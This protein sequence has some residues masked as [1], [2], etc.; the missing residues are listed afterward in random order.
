MEDCDSRRNRRVTEGRE[1]REEVRQ[2]SALTEKVLRVEVKRV[3][4]GPE[5]YTWLSEGTREALAKAIIGENRDRCRYC[6]YTGTTKRVAVHVRQHFAR[7]YC[8]CGENR[9]SRDTLSEH[10]KKLRNVAGHS[11]VHE[12]DRP[13]YSTFT[14][15][16]GWI[17]PPMFPECRPTLGR[18]LPDAR[19]TIRERLEVRGLRFDP[20][21]KRR[22]QVKESRVEVQKR[23]RPEEDGEE[24]EVPYASQSKRCDTGHQLKSKSRE[25]SQYK[26]RSDE[27]KRHKSKSKSKEEEPRSKTK[28]GTK[29]ER[30][31]DGEDRQKYKKSKKNKSSKEGAKTSKGKEP[32]ERTE[33]EKGSPIIDLVDGSPPP[34]A[35]LPI[36]DEEVELVEAH[37]EVN[38]GASTSNPVVARQRTT[39]TRQLQLLAGAALLRQQ[40]ALFQLQAQLAISRADEMEEAAREED[41]QDQE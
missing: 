34:E 19:N 30:N 5:R 20:P 37:S 8:K 14:R 6:S 13:T 27:G 38:R 32:I 35:E 29:E 9:T 7:Y 23:R 15:S 12:V 10:T 3:P 28:K 33:E 26:P 22:A 41:G 11:K 25:E 40:A 18:E 16:M 17:N 31:H 39:T 4:G 24:E 1:V 21:A 36:Q 2:E